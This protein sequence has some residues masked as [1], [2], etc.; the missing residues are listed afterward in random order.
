MLCWSRN[1]VCQQWGAHECAR[2]CAEGRTA[3]ACAL[4]VVGEAKDL[5]HEPA[6]V[7]VCGVG[8]CTHYL[9]QH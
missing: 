3:E 2:S 4:C 6:A 5:R 9:G 7:Q 8:A 1:T